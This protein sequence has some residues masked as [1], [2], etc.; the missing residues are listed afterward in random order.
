MNMLKLQKHK[1]NQQFEKDETK[2]IIVHIEE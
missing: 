1:L 2:Q